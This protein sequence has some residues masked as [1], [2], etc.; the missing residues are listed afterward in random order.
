M[1]LKPAAK[2][3]YKCCVKCR[4]PLYIVGAKYKFL[5]F[6]RRVLPR[7]FFLDVTAKLF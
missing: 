5:D 3:I 6:L 2:K 7:K 4:K 1:A